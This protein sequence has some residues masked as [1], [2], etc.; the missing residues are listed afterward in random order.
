[1]Q[2]SP[3]SRAHAI[4][5]SPVR[6]PGDEQRVEDE[7]REQEKNWDYERDE[8]ND[9]WSGAH[10]TPPRKERGR[11]T[12]VGRHPNECV[13]ILGGARGKLPTPMSGVS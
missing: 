12:D 10:F 8:G 7:R 3:H 4:V 9:E 13:G 6:D 11:S 5:P 1:M 2:Q